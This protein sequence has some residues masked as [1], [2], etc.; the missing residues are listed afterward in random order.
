[1]PTYTLAPVPKQA[2][3]SDAG[4]LIPNGYIYTYAVGTS[5]NA[6]TYTTDAGTAHTNPI[7][8]DANGRPP[9]EIYIPPGETQ[10]WLFH[11][12]DDALVWTAPTVT[13]L[14]L[15]SSNQ[16]VTG[17]AGED[18]DAE[19]VVYLSDGSGSLTAGRWYLADADLIYA[20]VTPV[21][22]MVTA[23]IASAATGTIRLAGQITVTGPLTA[24]S[25]YYVSAT[26][27]DL[28]ATE[29]T[30]SR[31]VGQAE[32]TTSLI[33]TPN[34][35]ERWKLQVPTEL[36]IA[37][38]AVV[39]TGNNHTIDTESDAATDDL[40]TITATN[41]RTGD[42]VVLAP[43]NVARVVTVKDG[44]G[45][46][47]LNGDYALDATD[48]TITLRYDGSNWVELCR[49]VNAAGA[50]KT[51]APTLQDAGPSDGSEV[52][53]ISFT[54]PAND[55]ADGD[56]I[57]VF[58]SA[59]FKNNQGSTAGWQLDL[60]WGSGSDVTLVSTTSDWSN[61]ATE[62]NQTLAICTMQ[63]VG[64]DLW[65]AGNGGASYGMNLYQLT[66]TGNM[67]WTTS[68]RVQVLASAPFSSESLVSIKA[69]L[70]ASHA[71]L[72]CKPQVALVRKTQSA[73]S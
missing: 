31:L 65:I 8:L 40:A 39:W 26:A 38:G 22:G 33:L 27:G 9:S 60:D 71:T 45:N 72:Y 62:R 24:G 18:L 34:P 59:K 6:A 48:A 51:Y 64:A 44:T 16:E 23:D 21:I 47:L 68:E 61:S 37:S 52:T 46:L 41:A 73:A 1:M 67:T 28:T 12:A 15:S 29:P 11:D 25:L 56:I 70:E 43:E 2:L 19:E 17:V 3:L 50:V 4:A 35:F 14:P 5:T 57:E 30:L 32:S 7:R 49:S 58:M 63:R 13:G 36:T 53:I 54:V 42:L 66:A 10:R 55:M 69:T 20:S